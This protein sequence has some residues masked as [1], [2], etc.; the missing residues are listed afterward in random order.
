MSTTEIIET[1]DVGAAIQQ[2]LN[3]VQTAFDNA[4]YHVPLQMVAKEYE[5][6]EQHLFE[7]E[8]APD[9][10]PWAKNKPRT[11]KGKGHDVVLH[12]KTGELGAALG[13][14]TSHSIRDIDQ[15][16]LTF[17]DDLPYSGF[18]TDGRPNMEP[19]EHVGLN[20]QMVDLTAEY[21][22]DGALVALGG[23]P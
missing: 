2:V 18:L 14:Q 3:G 9:G 19:R 4:N 13:G 1:N 23:V 8:I 11:I 6:F 12:G 10:S 20:E 7:R 17:G 15:R 5:R 21:V 16:F 22:A